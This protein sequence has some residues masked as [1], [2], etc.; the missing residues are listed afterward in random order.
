MS[1]IPEQQAGF[2]VGKKC[3][4]NDACGVKNGLTRRHEKHE[5]RNFFVPWCLRVSFCFPFGIVPIPD[6]TLRLICWNLH[7]H[8]YGQDDQQ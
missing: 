3:R 7:S 5:G 6:F 4:A 1:I 2:K 8:S